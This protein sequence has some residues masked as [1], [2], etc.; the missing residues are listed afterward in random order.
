ML[1]AEQIGRY[2]QAQEKP[3]FSWPGLWRKQYKIVTPNGVFISLNKHRPRLSHTALKKMCLEY[4]P[5]H[6]YMSVL[7]WL[8]PERVGSKKESMRAYPVGGEYV[9]DLDSYMS[10]T[11]HAR[12]LH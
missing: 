7:E 6:V 3:I 9:L 5:L 8:M 11:P 4:Q 2:Y 12:A 10:Y 1:E